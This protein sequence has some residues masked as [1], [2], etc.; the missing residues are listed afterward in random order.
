MNYCLW[1]DLVLER[2]SPA[3]TVSD[4]SGRWC[5][6]SG[7]CCPAC[8]CVALAGNQLFLGRAGCASLRINPVPRTA[9]LKEQ[10]RDSEILRWC[11]VPTAWWAQKSNRKFWSMLMFP[12][13][14]TPTSFLLVGGSSEQPAI[15][16]PLFP[17]RVVEDVCKVTDRR[18]AQTSWAKNCS[19]DVPLKC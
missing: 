16:I 7:C 3:R 10:G 12:G 19:E 11:K 18:C 17:W 2:E 6:H 8:A 13:M 14:R 9:E 1:R 4:I 15:R 5:S